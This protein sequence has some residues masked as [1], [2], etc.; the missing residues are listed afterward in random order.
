MI[1]GAAKPAGEQ[2][3]RLPGKT[4][5][6]VRIAL[7][8]GTAGRAALR[9]GPARW[10]RGCSA[11]GRGPARAAADLGE[12]RR[13]RRPAAQEPRRRERAV[14]DPRRR[15]RPLFRSLRLPARD[16]AGDRP[17]AAEGVVFERV[18]TPAV[19]TLGAMSSVWTSQ[20]PDRHH[21]EVSFS[22]RLPKDRLTLAEL[23]SAR[24]VHTAGF[25]ANA[26]AGQPLRL[27]PRLRRV[28]RGVPRRSAARATCSGRWC[29]TG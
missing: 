6:I 3:V 26:V 13:A 23:L 27:R 20:Y 5:D 2:E 8:V 21:S 10:H 17:L 9:L 16:D 4:G 14:R 18:Y 1:D 28:P 11:A 12:R 7:A 25:V 22:A 24:G 15:P 29:R 19:Y